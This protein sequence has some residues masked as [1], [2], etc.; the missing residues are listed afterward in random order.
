MPYAEYPG[1]HLWYEDSGGSG[2]PVVLMHAASGCCEAWAP[3]VPAL[4]AAGYR[5]VAY[6]RLGAG[7]TRSDGSGTARPHQSDDL[8]DLVE[9]LALDRFHIV[10]TAAGGGPA[11]DYAL[12]YADRLRSLVVAD[13]TGG[14]QDPDYLALLERIRTPEI[15]ALPVYL[16]ELSASYRGADPEGVKRWIEIEHAAGPFGGSE[17]RQRARNEITFAKLKTLSVPTLVLAG[18][19][20]MRTPPSAMRL[21]AAAIP[22]SRF[23]TVPEAGHAS[24][25]EQ[26]EVWNKIVL[27]FIG[28][29]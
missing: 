1:V 16:R 15:D 7:K 18:D 20:D 26:P 10:A 27:E 4:T 19:A 28:S 8:H 25:W 17:P 12:S 14:V 2:V 5:C 23:A 24:H 11:F 22:G 9:R 13:A 21:I 3:Q 6:D 29:H